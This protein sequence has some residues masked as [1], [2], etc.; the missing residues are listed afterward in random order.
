[1]RAWAD[2]GTKLRIFQITDWVGPDDAQ[3][4]WVP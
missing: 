1:V 3:N 4:V 2:E